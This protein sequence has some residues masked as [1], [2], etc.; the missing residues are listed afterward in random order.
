MDFSGKL[1]I[2]VIGLSLLTSVS[3]QA[4]VEQAYGY[5][6]KEFTTVMGQ[7]A[8][9]TPTS[10]LSHDASQIETDH[11]PMSYMEE[12]NG[13]GRDHSNEVDKTILYNAVDDTAQLEQSLMKTLDKKQHSS[14][15]SYTRAI[16]SSVN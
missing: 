15:A 12:I 5:N 11:H 1:K 3:A 4:T 8:K 14:R 9:M 6:K 7:F 2:G 13:E 10:Q 16:K